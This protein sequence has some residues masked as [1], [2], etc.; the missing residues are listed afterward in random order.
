MPLGS[1]LVTD[2]NGC[3]ISPFQRRPGNAPGLRPKPTIELG[4]IPR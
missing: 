1:V 2:Q 4:R 3:R